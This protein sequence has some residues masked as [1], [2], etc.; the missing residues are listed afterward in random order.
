MTDKERLEHLMTSE[1][2]RLVDEGKSKPEDIDN[3]LKNLRRE[4]EKQKKAYEE[5]QYRLFLETSEKVRLRRY[6]E[7]LIG[8]DN[9]EVGE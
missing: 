3:A 8:H 7:F 4:L 6:V 5:I 1:T 2:I 9:P